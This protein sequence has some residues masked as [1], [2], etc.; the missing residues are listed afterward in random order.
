MNHKAIRNNLWGLYLINQYHVVCS[1]M[2]KK[3]YSDFQMINKWYKKRTGRLP[4]IN[5]PKRFSEKQ[6]WY[7]LND[8]N[9]L[10]AT[11]ADKYDV[12]DYIIKCGY[13][14]LLNDIYG[15][16]D[17]VKDIDITTFPEQFV[18]KA[19]HGSGFNLIVKNKNQV[20]W[21]MW[22]RIMKSWLHQ[23]IYDSVES[24]FIKT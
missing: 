18:L 4:D 3:K 12:R 21:K 23:D 20:N 15:V 9:P 7:K 22:K 17:C 24:G 16:Y 1:K 13:G 11:C 8:R 6:Q 10:Q 14:H 2:N 19:A 5:N